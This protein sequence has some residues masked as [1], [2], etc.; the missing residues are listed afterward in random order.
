MYWGYY[1]STSSYA[2]KVQDAYKGFM[3]TVA[4]YMVRDNAMNP[5]DNT[6]KINIEQ[7]VNDAYQFEYQLANVTAY[8][9]PSPDPHAPGNRK[10][11]SEL[12]TVADQVNWVSFFQYMFGS[13]NVNGDTYVVLLEADYLQKMSNMIKNWDPNTKTRV[14]NNY[15]MWRLMQA[16]AQ[17]LSWE[18][19]HA[20]REFYVA[21]TGRAQFLGTYRFCFN[22]MKSKMPDALGALFVQDHFAD[23]AKS[24][25]DA[26]VSRLKQTIATRI[27]QA[28]WMD[29]STKKYASSKMQS[30]VDK[31][32]Y[33]TAAVSHDYLDRKYD[34]LKIN[35]TNYFANILS[36]NAFEKND[37]TNQLVRGQD[38]TKWRYNTYDVVAHMYNPWN[39][40]IV[41]AGLFQFPIYT[42]IMP[43]HARFGAMGSIVAHELMHGIDE[44]GGY[45][46]KNGTVFDWWS[47]KTTVDYL[48]SKRCVSDYYT[49]MTVGFRI[50]NSEGT[51]ETRKVPINARRYAFEGL[52][53]TA[54]VRMAYYAY[55]DWVSQNGAEKQVP[56]LNKNNEQAFFISYAQTNCFNRN[57]GYGYSQAM[58]GSY[59]ESFKVN[60]ALAQLDEFV[61]AFS[62]PAGSTMNA[63]KK[64]NVY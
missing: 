21:R 52:T 32:A 33:D 6:V 29:A 35:A 51:V 45:F 46:L 40:I 43:Q 59:P 64:C 44:Y 39:E 10:K 42:R 23:N 15:L 53:E 8:T 57:E 36:M 11:I 7:F 58:Q 3:R 30:V 28:T 26:I 61:Q 49:N 19:V 54:G 4:G 62:C 50:P 17:D 34:S 22:Y 1:I 27:Q 56:G 31:I 13:N 24:E 55:K 18:Y 20:N 47:N 5:T 48:K 14:L 16:Y 25:V 38:K 41:P 12:N 9:Q 63:D 37:W 60:T 2:A